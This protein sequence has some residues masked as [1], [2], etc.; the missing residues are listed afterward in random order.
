M[1]MKP[2]VK[3][4][5]RYDE[6]L[7]ERIRVALGPRPDVSERKMFG[8]LAFMLGGHMTCGVNG[9]DLMARVGPEQYGEALDEPDARPMDFT[10]RPLKGFV[11]VS[12]AIDDQRLATW[13]ERCVRFTSSL[14]PK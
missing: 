5:P 7:V 8:G 10:G 9:G 13:V 12:G 14:P 2:R 11:Y 6:A 3:P 1:G 4:S